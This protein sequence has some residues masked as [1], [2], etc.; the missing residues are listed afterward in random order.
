MRDDKKKL[1][2]I[3]GD[4]IRKARQAKGMTQRDLAAICGYADSTTIYKVEKGLQDLPLSKAKRVCRALDVDFDYLKGNI[5]FVYHSD[6]TAIL[7]EVDSYGDT[8]RRELRTK[9]D[10]LLNKATD[11]QL[12]ELAAFINIY[13]KKENSDGNTDLE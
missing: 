11:P 9:I 12:E 7:I 10:G 5:D 1:L 13:L 3:M 6:G 2:K 8:R 4:R